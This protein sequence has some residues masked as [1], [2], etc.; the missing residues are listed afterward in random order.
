VGRVVEQRALLLQI[1]DA[2]A[3]GGLRLRELGDLPALRE[4]PAKR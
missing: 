1:R 2:D 3:L 4:V